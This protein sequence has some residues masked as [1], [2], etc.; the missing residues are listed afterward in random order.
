[1]NGRMSLLLPS[2]LIN[3][4]SMPSAALTMSAD[5]GHGHAADSDE[6]ESRETRTVDVFIVNIA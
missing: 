1:L 4:L 6:K 3:I 5:S 2:R